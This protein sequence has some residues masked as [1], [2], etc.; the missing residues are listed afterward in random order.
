MPLGAT[1]PSSRTLTVTGIPP[2]VRLT[3]T[4]SGPARLVVAHGPR[5]SGK[6]TLL[7]QW[8]SG[9]SPGVE[10]S[11]GVIDPDPELVGNGYWREVAESVWRL[12]TQ[13]EGTGAAT[14][15]PQDA[16]GPQDAYEQLADMLRRWEGPL[17]LMLDDL[18]LAVDPE[19]RLRELIRRA[20]TGGFRIVATTRVAM[21]WSRTAGVPGGTI[22]VGPE[23]LMLTDGE[24]AEVVERA[25]VSTLNQVPL[26]SIAAETGRIAGLV[27]VGVEAL[28]SSSTSRGDPADRIRG[29][30][31]HVVLRILDGSPELVGLRPDLYRSAVVSPL[32]SSAA[33]VAVGGSG[34]RETTAHDLLAAAERHGLLVREPGEAEPTWRYPGPVRGSILR[35]ARAEEPELLLGARLAV[36]DHWLRHGRPHAAFVLAIDAERWDLVLEILRAHWT[37]LYTSNFLQMDGDLRRIPADVLESEPLFGTLRRMHNQFSAPKDTPAPA[38][39]IDASPEVSDDAERLMRMISLRIEGRF[40]DAVSEHDALNRVPVPDLDSS[41]QTERDGPAFVFL[42]LGLSLLLVGRFDDA[43]QLF[44]RAHRIGAG[45]FIERDAAGK[46]TLVNALLGHVREAESWWDEERRHPQ[47]PPDSEFVVRPAGMIGAALARLDRLDIEPAIGLVTDLG[48]PADQEELWGLALYVYG[49]IALATGTPA[50]GLRYVEHHM[51]RFPGLCDNGAVVG[52]LLDAVRADL[53]LAMGHPGEAAELLAGSTHPLTAPARGRTRLH[54]GDHMGALEV[55]R[56]H[57]G[58]LRC[59][60]RDSVEL[61]LIGAAASVAASARE[62]AVEYLDGAIT[63]SRLTGVIRPFTTLPR[64]TLA[65]LATLGPEIPSAVRV[66]GSPA[67]ARESP[68]LTERERAILTSLETGDSITAIARQH[69]VSVNTVK[70]QLRAVYRKLGVRSRGAAV[71]EARR[72]GLL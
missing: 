57:H 27:E 58:D 52:P 11:A 26:S 44:R 20:P 34:G 2:R 18:H 31:D 67:P 68:E 64:G 14:G 39:A 63:T 49:Q 50:D 54:E 72:L 69:F 21:D 28:R 51:R 71:D 43:H 59:T 29:E 38:P 60:A 17:T 41:T 70:T 36:I 6:T 9:N 13:G 5:M 12:R 37:T 46:L 42:H 19:D 4:L 23:D 65:T 10:T 25:G 7:R 22:S 62:E 55:V 15:S 24:L 53:H 16:Y 35:I 8:L 61:S 40:A 56:A 3:A 47:L 33:A 66:A 30:I 1:G 32:T 45:S 48:A